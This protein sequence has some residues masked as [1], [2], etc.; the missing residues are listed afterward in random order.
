MTALVIQ[1]QLSAPGGYL[2]DW[3]Q[4][5]GAELQI[6][7]IDAE[8]GDRPVEAAGYD[9]IVSLGSEVASF[10]DSIPWIERELQLLRDAAVHDVP[11]IGICFGGQL[12]A[13]A[14]GGRTFRAEQLEIGW[15]P[16]PTTDSSLVPDGPW[17]E[18]HYDTFTPPPGARL[19]AERPTGP[20]AFVVGRSLGL[21]FHPEVTPAIVEGWVATDRD[22]LEHHG[23]DGDRLI[24]QTR[25]L[26]AVS[27]AAAWRLF[28]GFLDRVARLT[29]WT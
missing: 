29:Q 14:L 7:H 5:R 13:R 16:V 17:F 9:L 2:T 8:N 3:L 28:D 18:W 23:V 1:H 10:D 15:L 26:E 12:L 27:R 24:E 19:I 20:Q 25:E 22:E 6:L 21:Q 11:M 4:E